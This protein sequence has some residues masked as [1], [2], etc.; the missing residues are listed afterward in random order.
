MS[1]NGV[2]HAIRRAVDGKGK[3]LALTEAKTLVARM[4]QTGLLLGPKIGLVDRLGTDSF[5]S[6]PS[7]A[8]L[9]F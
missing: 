8:K 9:L 4:L 7:A 6:M 5:D 2:L 1:I 3:L